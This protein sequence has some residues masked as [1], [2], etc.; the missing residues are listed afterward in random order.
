MKKTTLTIVL[1]LLI[2][3]SIKA[4]NI[5]INGYLKDKQTGEVLIGASIYNV[6][7]K[8]GTTTNTY[9]YYTLTV[10]K[11]DSIVLQYSFIGYRS[12]TK[13]ISAQKSQKIDVILQSSE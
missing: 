2:A 7:L 8:I 13:K 11:Q 6:K 12:I 5:T 4:Q 9:G 3:L 10:P 1:F